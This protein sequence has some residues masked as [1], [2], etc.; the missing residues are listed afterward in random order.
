MVVTD[1]MNQDLQLERIFDYFMDRVVV[2]PRGCWVWQ[3]CLVNGYAVG[4]YGVQLM[5]L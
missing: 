4:R 2:N 3:Q 1:F 5:T